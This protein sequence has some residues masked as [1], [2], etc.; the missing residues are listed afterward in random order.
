MNLLFV[1]AAASLRRGV[2]PWYPRALMCTL[3]LGEMAFV[4]AAQGMFKLPGSTINSLSSQMEKSVS[5]LYGN[6]WDIHGS[7]FSG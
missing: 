2:I 6:V 7:F 3:H 4:C 1:V 5:H